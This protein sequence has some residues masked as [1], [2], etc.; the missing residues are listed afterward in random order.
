MSNLDNISIGLIVVG[1]LLVRQL[2]PRPASATV[3]WLAVSLI[4]G[5]GP[6]S[7]A[8]HFATCLPFGCH[9]GQS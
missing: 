2:Q 4:A 1:L 3:A 6:A 5:A 9:Q 7:V 8:A